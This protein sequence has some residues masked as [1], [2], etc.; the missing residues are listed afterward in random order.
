MRLR[1]CVCVGVCE[2]WRFPF[3]RHC[4]RV[5]E[6]D[7]CYC[8]LPGR[9][10]VVQCGA[11]LNGHITNAHG[12]ITLRAL[13]HIYIIILCFMQCVY[14]STYGGLREIFTCWLLN[15]YWCATFNIYLISDRFCV[16][17]C[18]CVCITPSTR[19]CVCVVCVLCVSIYD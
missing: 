11:R 4:R 17:V 13:I 6:S 15:C 14:H 3:F 8:N 1:L 9:L 10:L 19:Y 5:T 7:F 12:A 18:V 16:C 2:T